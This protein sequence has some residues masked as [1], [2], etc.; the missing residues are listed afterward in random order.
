MRK[1]VFITGATGT[2]GRALSLEFARTNHDCALQYRSEAGIDLL[3]EQ[4][5]ATGMKGISIE[6][7]FDF[8]DI[9]GLSKSITQILETEFGGL[10]IAVLNASSQEL[11][12][13]N[14]LS[15]VDWDAMYVNSLRQTAVLL[16]TL[17][18]FMQTRANPV[19]VVVGSIE[20]LRPNVNHAPYG[21]FKAALHHLV[22]AAAYEL[23]QKNIRVVGVAPGLINRDGLETDWKSGVESFREH[24]ALHKLI[25]A[26]EVASVIR[27][28]A[29]DDASAITGIT[30]PVDAGWS[31]HP[32]W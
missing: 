3:L 23:G 19:I 10:D 30:I 26:R 1:S 28:L 32:G 31:A 13:W 16:K 5:R 11:T 29:S 20:G 25:E 8:E 22:T 15:A 2:L 14:E 27:F 9:D 21:V 17:A 24:S 18:D 7:N 4:V 12:A 6:A